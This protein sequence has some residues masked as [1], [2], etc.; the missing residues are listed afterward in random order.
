MKSSGTRR[1]PERAILYTAVVSKS[2][3]GKTEAGGCQLAA[4]ARGQNGTRRV[5][6]AESV[7]RLDGELLREPRAGTIDPARARP[8]ALS[9]I[10][11][12]SS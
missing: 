9:Q 6:R 4:P 7:G 1:S 11:A 2:P 5:I 8:T 12:A 3:P 10:A